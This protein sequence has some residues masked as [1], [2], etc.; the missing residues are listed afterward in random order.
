MAYGNIKFE[1]GEEEWEKFPDYKKKRLRKLIK[2]HYD[3]DIDDLV[4]RDPDEDDERW[5]G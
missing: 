2:E 5:L 1:I 3:V 4:Y